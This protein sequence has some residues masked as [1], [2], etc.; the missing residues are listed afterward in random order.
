MNKVKIKNLQPLEDEHIL[1]K[2]TNFIKVRL[3]R[4]I[5]PIGI[6]VIIT[7][8][9]CFFHNELAYFYAKWRYNSGDRTGAKAVFSKLDDFNDSQIYLTD[10]AYADACEYMSSGDYLSAV[11]LLILLND[12]SDSTALLNECYLW[13]L[14]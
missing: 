12:Y 2:I 3:W 6:I 13:L 10:I 4:I 9:I 11:D 1:K 8:S 7:L 14:G 5:I